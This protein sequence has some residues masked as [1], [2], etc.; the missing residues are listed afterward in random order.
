MIEQLQKEMKTNKK[1]TWTAKCFK[2]IREFKKTPEEVIDSKTFS[3]QKIIDDVPYYLSERRVCKSSLLT[4]KTELDKELK[5]SNTDQILKEVMTREEVVQLFEKIDISQ[6]H[7]ITDKL[8][9][10]LVYDITRN[11]KIKEATLSIIAY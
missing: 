9:D 3:T 7:A 11:R 5:D 6:N 2:A 10:Q 4:F 1:E 8:K